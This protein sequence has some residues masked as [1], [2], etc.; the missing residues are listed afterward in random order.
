MTPVRQ[1]VS[2][3]KMQHRR[4][5]TKQKLRVWPRRRRE[6][7][8]WPRPQRTTSATNRGEVYFLLKKEEDSKQSL[9]SFFSKKAKTFSSRLWS[10]WMMSSLRCWGLCEKRDSFA[11][12]AALWM[13]RSH[14]VI[15]KLL[16]E[17]PVGPQIISIACEPIMISN[18]VFIQLLA[19]ST[20]NPNFSRKVYHPMTGYSRQ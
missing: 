13:E 2:D 9:F 16:D 5:E 3:Y 19:P 18:I 7:I 4:G 17:V 1:S 12:D 15:L 8:V 10:W 14:V 11:S 20:K 6:R